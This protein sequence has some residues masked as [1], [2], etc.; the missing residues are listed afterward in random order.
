VVSMSRPTAAKWGAAAPSR[1][2]RTLESYR[3]LGLATV[4]ALL[5]A[6]R[7]PARARTTEIQSRAELLTTSAALTFAAVD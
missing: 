4:L 1:S 3:T 6:E 7:D 2:N 5:A